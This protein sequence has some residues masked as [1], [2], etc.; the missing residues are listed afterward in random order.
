MESQLRQSQRLESLGQLAGGVAHDFNNLLGAILNYSAFVAEEVAPEAGQP[1]WQAV[2][3][4]I[5]QIQQAARRAADLTHQLLAFARREVIQPRVLDLNEA[6]AGV[7]QLLQRTLGEHVELSITAASGPLPVL[8]DQGQLEQ[9]L[10]N[11]AVNA[12]D[13]MPAGGRLSIDTRKT[14]VDESYA[15]DARTSPPVGM[16]G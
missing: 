1:R 2:L 10:V 4:D 15:A 3:D 8:A 9:V 14:Q 16:S 5:R 7:E 13:A 6:V 11:L 12:R